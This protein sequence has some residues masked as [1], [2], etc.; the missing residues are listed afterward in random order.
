M[1][2]RMDI[3][4]ETRKQLNDLRANMMKTLETGTWLERNAAAL[5]GQV[6][7]ELL[8]K[9]GAKNIHELDIKKLN[10]LIEALNKDNARLSELLTGEQSAE[11]VLNI[12]ESLAANLKARD[13]LKDRQLV[14][15]GKRNNHYRK[16]GV[17]MVRRAMT[18]KLIE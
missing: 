13:L 11:A 17:K 7:R 2:V 14:M 15:K 16:M 8:D 1:L 6:K 10:K 4:Q 18:N 5:R 12:K 3:S 9:V